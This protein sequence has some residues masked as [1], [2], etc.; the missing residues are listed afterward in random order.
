MKAPRRRG[1][2]CPCRPSRVSLA[3]AVLRLSAGPPPTFALCALGGQASSCER[4][5]PGTVEL[6]VANH[7]GFLTFAG[8]PKAIEGARYVLRSVGH[9]IPRSLSRLPSGRHTGLGLPRREDEAF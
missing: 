6:C 7:G 3:G 5:H 1:L 2:R 8:Y 9:S 4:A